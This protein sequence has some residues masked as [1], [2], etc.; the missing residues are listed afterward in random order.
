MIWTR[1]GP[2]IILNTFTQTGLPEQ[3]SNFPM[4]LQHQRLFYLILQF[5]RL[6]RHCKTRNFFWVT[7]SKKHRNSWWYATT[8]DR[9][10]STRTKSLKLAI[11]IIESSRS[12]FSLRFSTVRHCRRDAWHW[13]SQQINI[14][15]CSVRFTFITS[16]DWTSPNLW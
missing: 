12:I 14:S 3:S 11:D 6:T 9:S 5:V 1:S 2:P 8:F 13:T 15:C 4:K 7:S 16:T 10:A